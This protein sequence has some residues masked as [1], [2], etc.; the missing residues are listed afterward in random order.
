MSDNQ[1]ITKY[2]IEFNRHMSQVRGYGEGAL[3]RHFYNRL[4]EQLKDEIAR[5]GKPCSLHDMWV[6]VQ[7]IDARYW[8]CKAEQARHPKSVTSTSS[9][10]NQPSRS[11]NKSAKPA[12]PPSTSNP[13]SNPNSSGKSSKGSGQFQKKTPALSDLS[14]KLGKD[15]KLTNEE[16]CCHFEN[17]LCMFCGQSG[18][19][20]KDCPRASSR[21][22]KARAADV[23]TPAVKPED[24]SES[25]K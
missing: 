15:G 4:P 8:E 23:A 5:I 9:S 1:R 6:L 20:A 14:S 17:N 16:R 21:A 22:A 24:S 10:S 13:P 11:A 25:K 7:Q 19:I 12:P 2:V 18:H 3:Q